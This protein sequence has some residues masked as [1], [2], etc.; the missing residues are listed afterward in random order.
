MEGDDESSSEGASEEK[1][2]KPGSRV[3]SA[4]P[5]GGEH[6]YSHT[7]KVYGASTVMEYKS[8]KQYATT[9]R[10][11]AEGRRG[12]YKK[13]DRRQ[14]VKEDEKTE[15][16]M[17]QNRVYPRKTAKEKI[18][19]TAE[20]AVEQAKSYAKKPPTNKERLKMVQRFRKRRLQTTRPRYGNILRGPGW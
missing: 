9:A 19:S 2:S 16:T 7:G 20:R 5:Q 1:F 17:E 8:R 11:V 15:E 4:N 13:F 3:G 10:K 18:E 6:V 12:G 14:K